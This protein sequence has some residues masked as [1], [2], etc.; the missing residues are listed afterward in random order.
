MVRYHVYLDS[1]CDVFY[2]EEKNTLFINTIKFYMYDIEKDSMLCE[3]YDVSYDNDDKPRS[4][5]QEIYRKKI[6]NM[7]IQ[8]SKEKFKQKDI[9]VPDLYFWKYG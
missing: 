7:F 4:P 8:S 9:E 2:M 3:S 5:R 6:L 1:E